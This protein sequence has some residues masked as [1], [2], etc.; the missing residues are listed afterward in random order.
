MFCESCWDN[1]Y[2]LTSH[3]P[4][5]ELQRLLRPRLHASVSGSGSGSAKWKII[6][7]THVGYAKPLYAS[8]SR[9]NYRLIGT[10]SDWNF[11]DP[12]L[13]P[14]PDTDTDTWRQAFIIYWGAFVFMYPDL[15]TD[16]W[17]RGLQF[18]FFSSKTSV[19][20]L[21]VKFKTLI[22]ATVI[23]LS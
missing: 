7:G 20:V 22:V 17:R 4:E 11:T 15:D 9:K 3:E 5:D 21:S 16:V 13:D 18:E 6:L 8:V 23:Y 2:E 1:S 12:D 14:D 19:P 10:W